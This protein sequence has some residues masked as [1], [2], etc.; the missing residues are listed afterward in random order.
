M[1]VTCQLC[2]K[3][4]A[5]LIS[6]SHLKQHNVSSAEYKDIH[7]K[8][9]LASAEYRNRR[10]E[11][12][13]GKNN[14]N[15]GNAMTAKT[16]EAIS[17]ANKGKTAW[18]KGKECTQSIKE[19]ISTANKGKTAWN[20]GKTHTEETKNK[21][22][23]ARKKQI[24]SP[25]AVRKAITTK[26]KNGYDFAPFKGHTHSKKSKLLIS[27]A[28]K[29]TAQ[30]KS[31]NALAEYKTRIGKHGYSIISS[32]AS[33]AS[34]Q[35]SKGHISEFTRQ[36]LT[37][38]KFKDT[39]CPICY[40][41]DIVVS[42][43]E[44]EVREFV[45]SIV[46]IVANAR[47]IIAPLELDIVIPSLHLA[48]E[49]N[50]LYWH[51]EIHKENNYHKIKMEKCNEAGYRLI[52]IF[53]DEWLNNKDIVKSRLAALLGQNKVLYARK[54]KIQEISAKEANVFLNQNHLQGAGR[55]NVAYGLFDN[56]SLVAVMTFLNSDIS[57]GVNGWELNRFA[58]RLLTNVVGGASKLLSAFIKNNNPSAITTFADLR[59]SNN[60]SFYTTIGFNFVHNSVPGYW[61]VFN[62]DIKRIHRYTLRKPQGCT[63]SEKDLR[64]QEGYYRIYDCGNA[65]YIWESQ[66]SPN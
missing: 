54:T 7:G 66:K 57:K 34:I 14:P 3:E 27:N 10:S 40:P 4:F 61:Y 58:S 28:T 51:S 16:K 63:L 24:I 13:R 6:S 50:G 30:Q 65:K 55:S 37:Q 2:K 21:I 48:I 36:Y 60:S 45:S 12:N 59:W 62:N 41:R 11:S 1:P 42:K 44:L 29:K 43:G 39:I 47:G 33:H 64:K 20:K 53:E 9:S 52:Q 18:N 22:R 46:P 5:S 23:N 31:D 35:C 17:T 56:D 32:S 26:R 15:Y 38:S 8:D 25:E 49:Y 19:A